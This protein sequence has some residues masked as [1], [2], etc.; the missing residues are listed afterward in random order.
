MKR[1]TVMLSPI[2][3]Y[4]IQKAEAIIV[5]NSSE[6][7]ILA[8]NSCC[9]CARSAISGT[10]TTDSEPVRVVGAISRGR[11]IPATRPYSAVA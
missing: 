2:G 5:R 4:S 8:V 7:V 1:S 3:T 6:E 9:F 11:A 10:S